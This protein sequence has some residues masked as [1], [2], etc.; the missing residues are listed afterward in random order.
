[1]HI[2][3]NLNKRM[4][5]RLFRIHCQYYDFIRC[6]GVFRNNGHA[7]PAVRLGSF[8]VWVNLAK[9]IKIVLKPGI[10]LRRT[11]FP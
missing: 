9:R 11:E 7:Q 3:A 4:I 8:P 2:R 1:M 10:E 6:A 5:L